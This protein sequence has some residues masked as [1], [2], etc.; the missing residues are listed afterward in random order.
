[1]E[2]L[3]DAG[4]MIHLRDGANTQYVTGTAFILFLYSNILRNHRETVK[5]GKQQQFSA[6]RIREFAKQ[7]V[8]ITNIQ[9]INP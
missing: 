8:Q 9:I 2:L 6:D 1:M 7:Q 3:N 5:C 4:G